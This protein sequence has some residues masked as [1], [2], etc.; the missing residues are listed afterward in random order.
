MKSKNFR[1]RVISAAI[2]APAFF[3]TVFFGDWWFTA[4]VAVFTLMGLREWLKIVDG[5]LPRPLEILAGL[6]LLATLSLATGL[7]PASGLAA[8]GILTASLLIAAM[9][10]KRPH[11]AWIAIGLPYM[12]GGGLAIVA[13]RACDHGLAQV[14]YLLAIVWGTDTGAYLAGKIIGGPKLAP[15]ISPKK[16]LAGSLGGI[17]LAILLGASVAAGFKAQNLMMAI[18]FA[19]VL[20]IASQLGDLFKSWFKRR[21]NM[22]DSGDLIP[23][24][25]G[26]LDR[27][28]GLAFASILFA[29]CEDPIRQLIGW[30]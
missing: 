14:S 8:L 11:P 29:L 20:S 1:Q 13:L 21:A 16:T 17:T 25:G 27:I 22:K 6:S 7:T 3:A 24:H 15:S 30:P 28:D 19:I 4:T 23:G 2:M 12:A 9:L 18:V 26:V 10:A 5:T